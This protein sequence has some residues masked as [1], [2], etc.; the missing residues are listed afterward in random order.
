[1]RTVTKIA[2]ASL[3]LLGTV[4]TV[5]PAADAQVYN[6]PTPGYC[7]PLTSQITN[8]IID[9]ATG[10]PI[11][12][13]Q[14]LARYPSNPANWTYDCNSGLWTDNGAQAP[15]YQGPAYYQAPAY[16]QGRGSYR[17]SRNVDRNRGHQQNRGSEQ[18]RG[19]GDRNQSNDQHRGHE[20]DRH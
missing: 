9:P 10:R 18:N 11:T 8:W 14:Y 20:G 16:Y 2:L 3:A 15:A 17:E 19:H 6:G 12:E 1:M 5:A 13:Q 4:A 7:G